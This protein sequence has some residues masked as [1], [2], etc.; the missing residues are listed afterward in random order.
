MD[1][2]FQLALVVAFAAVLLITGQLL[3]E[4]RSSR[5]F[6]GTCRCRSNAWSEN[7]IVHGPSLMNALTSPRP[8][9]SNPRREANTSRAISLLAGVRNHF[10]A[11]IL[12]RT[13][14]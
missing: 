4:Y 8:G 1:E 7:S 10:H 2:L 6:D 5:I 9:V 13:T 3:M 14:M 12:V 11:F